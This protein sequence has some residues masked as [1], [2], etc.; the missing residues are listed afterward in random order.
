MDRPIF[1]ILDGHTPVPTDIDAYAA[2]WGKQEGVGERRVAET[3]LSTCRVSTVFLAVDHNH[4]GVGPPVL[5]ETMIFGGPYDQYQNRYV[6]WEEAE[7][8]HQEAV[9]LAEVWDGLEVEIE[10][11]DGSGDESVR[12]S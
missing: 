9:A 1:Y 4:L 3:I 10:L 12:G 11:R 2:W 7:A 8:G 6:T 5:F